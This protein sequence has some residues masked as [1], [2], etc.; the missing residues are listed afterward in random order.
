MT[1]TPAE[2]SSPAR[3][4]NSSATQRSAGG[5]LR[6][7]MTHNLDC[8][9]LMLGDESQADAMS[10]AIS[11]E[12]GVTVSEP[13]APECGGVWRCLA[14]ERLSRVQLRT[15]AWHTEPRAKRQTCIDE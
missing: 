9:A 7:S 15:G 14:V 1:P 10:S 13:L 5:R 6:R 8:F 4:M 11:S 12:E 3:F 2:A